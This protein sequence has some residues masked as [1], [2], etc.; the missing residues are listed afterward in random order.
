VWILE[1]NP[2]TRAKDASLGILLSVAGGTELDWLKKPNT[3]TRSHRAPSFTTHLLIAGGVS[4][5]GGT[6]QC[7][8]RRLTAEIAG[9]QATI[10][11]YW[12]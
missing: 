5:V 10:S 6:S 3:Y 9:L 7:G 2:G 12:G 1:P 8:R 11:P 4:Y